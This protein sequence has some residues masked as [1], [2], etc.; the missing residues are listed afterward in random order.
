M[1]APK[2]IRRYTEFWRPLF[3]KFNSAPEKEVRVR[4]GSLKEARNIRL[5]FYKAREAQHHEDNE[6]RK[7]CA[8]PAE[9]AMMTFANL[10]R[11]EVRLEGTTVV[12]GFKDN[13]RTAE[14]LKAAI[15]DPDNEIDNFLEQG[16]Q[17]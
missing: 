3:E 17:R 11:K 16:E 5:E 15:A 8:S 6:F 10:N 9:V 2:D 4:C 7:T 1:S 14:L 13:N 12:F